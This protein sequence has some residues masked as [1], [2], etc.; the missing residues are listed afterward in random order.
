M[1]NNDILIV[2]GALVLGGAVALGGCNSGGGTVSSAPSGS[3]TGVITG[4][5]SVY[6]N[7]VEYSSNSASFSVDGVP[8]S[9]D[10]DLDV[11]MR[12]SV[13]G[14][15]NPDG[16]TGTAT[17]ISYADELEGIVMDVTGVLPDGTG[18]MNIMGQTVMLNKL[19]VFN[20]DVPAI[21]AAT[22]IVTGNVVEV[23]GHSDGTGSIMASRIEV[24][25]ADLASYLAGS[26][27]SEIELKGIVTGIE[28]FTATFA[29]GNLTV[30]YGGAIL[31]S[32][33]ADPAVWE[34]L[35]VEVKTD[36]APTDNGDGTFSLAATRVELEGDGSI[37]V[38]A[39]EGDEVELRGMIMSVSSPTDFML[40]GQP[41]TIDTGS[42][43][44][45][46]SHITA[47]DATMAGRIVEAEGFIDASGVLIAYSVELEAGDD[48]SLTEYRDYVQSIDVAGG[49]VT[50]QSGQVFIVT[51]NTIKQD[52][53]SSNPEHYFDLYDLR[54]GDYVEIYAYTDA[55]GDL[56]ASKLER[57]DPPVA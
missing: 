36:T 35:Y 24:K 41:V 39:S 53:Q 34:G 25:A 23:S 57:E 4:F 45:D 20:S 42:A 49:T 40:D 55:N 48:G 14:S 29:I 5:G 37:G 52:S 44:A 51:S 1:N 26:P 8:G 9:S 38:D 50:L 22:D 12:V 10:Y 43:S 27:G 47:V 16:T 30:Y 21:A 13:Q 32:L 46:D 11:G 6:V 33:P 54:S 3:I 7:G 56:V 17:S 15:V 18:T 19:T 31:D 2:M 28:P